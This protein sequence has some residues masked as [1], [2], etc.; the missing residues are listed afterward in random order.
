MKYRILIVVLLAM[1]AAPSVHGFGIG[2]I[3]VDKIISG[4]KQFA[5]AAKG[6]VVIRQQLRRLCVD[7]DRVIEV[8][9]EIMI[10]G[11]LQ[12][13]GVPLDIAAQDLAVRL[14]GCLEVTAHKQSRRV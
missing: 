10:V 9:Q 5:Q 1:L 2:E 3:N 11:D 13:G 8:T 7:V 14:D 4:G 12:H 6:A